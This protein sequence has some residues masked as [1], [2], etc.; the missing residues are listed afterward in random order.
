[1]DHRAADL[2]DV[3]GL[4]MI[5]ELPRQSPAWKLN[6]T[7]ASNIVETVSPSVHVAAYH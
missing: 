6:T 3:A 4:Q 2:G 7:H 1:M 5:D